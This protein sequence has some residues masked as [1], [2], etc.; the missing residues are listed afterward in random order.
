MIGRILGCIA[1]LAASFRSVVR[2]DTMMVYY[3]RAAARYRLGML[4]ARAL[5]RLVFWVVPIECKESDGVV[6]AVR[7]VRRLGAGA[8]AWLA[9]ER[10]REELVLA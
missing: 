2:H 10:K 3:S 4:W 5:W 9:W 8:M 6:R 7:W 1:S